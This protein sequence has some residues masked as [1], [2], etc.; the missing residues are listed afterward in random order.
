MPFAAWLL[1]CTQVTP[2][3]GDADP[4]MTGGDTA[5]FPPSDAPT[6]ALLG[7]L[8]SQGGLAP[9]DIDRLLEWIDVTYDPSRTHRVVRLRSVDGYWFGDPE[10]VRDAASVPG[11]MVDPDGTHWVVYND[12]D[13]SAL[14]A[15]LRDDPRAV[16][17]RGLVGVGGLGLLRRPA[18]GSAWEEVPVDLRLPRPA[19]V[20]DPDIGL[21]ADG[22]VRLAWFGTPFDA[23]DDPLG[24]PYAF[25]LPHRFWVG[26][27]PDVAR[28]EAPVLAVASREGR[29]GGVDPFVQDVPGGEVLW[30]GMPETPM[31]GWTRPDGEVWDP[32]AAPD[33]RANVAWSAPHMLR[34]DSGGWRGYG[35][36]GDLGG[37]WMRTSPDGVTWTAAQAVTDV[38]GLSSPAVVRDPDGTWWLYAV[39]AG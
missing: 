26:R 10:P 17:R 12:K 23:T 15:I 21:D 9:A 13:L 19:V 18:G 35:H 36:G 39:S 28:L 22:N 32:D 3:F 38:D 5:S 11:A 6:D 30:V 29:S 24:D 25:A 8:E 16:W 14:G 7:V 34:D 1:A 2:S 37:V 20:V 33:V 4:S 27:G 31:P